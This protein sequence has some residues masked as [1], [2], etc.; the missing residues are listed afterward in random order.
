VRG[1]EVS[2]RS[3]PQAGLLIR[4]MGSMQRVDVL[5]A[6]GDTVGQEWVTLGRE[7][8]EMRVHS[9][10]KRSTLIM[11]FADMRTV[12]DSVLHVQLDSA[13]AETEVL[14][15]G[16]RILGR[17]TQRVRLRHGFR[18][19][20]TRAG[21][22]QVIHVTSETNALIAPSVPEMWGANS[23]VSLTSGS[24]AS[25]VEQVFGRGSTQALH[26]SAAPMPTGL[27]MRSVT[28]TRMTSEG[29]SVFPLTPSPD[30]EIALDSVDV[31]S[32]ARERLPAALFAEPI[33]YE[34]HEFGALMRQ[35]M[36]TFDSLSSSMQGLA[37]GAKPAKARPAK[38]YKPSKP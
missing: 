11:R 25:L 29:P 2:S 38:S 20:T 5:T 19:Q 3:A 21:K 33:G 34:V 8:D 32:I 35:L 7:P 14:G 16:E 18:M 26:R 13:T 24:T 10:S 30:G 27:A 22:T 6:T 1:S 36:A 17:E 12:F 4:R 31:I 15:V 23:V 37:K 28:R 9:A